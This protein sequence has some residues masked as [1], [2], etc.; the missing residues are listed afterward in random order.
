MLNYLD[1]IDKNF[2]I[3]TNPTKKEVIEKWSYKELTASTNPLIKLL[4]E[5]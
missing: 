4:T 3:I 2:L 1:L 5:H